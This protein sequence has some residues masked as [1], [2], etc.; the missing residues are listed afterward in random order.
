MLDEGGVWF[1]PSRGAARDTRRRRNR[2]PTN[3]AIDSGA[4]LFGN[5]TPQPPSPEPHGYLALAVFDTSAA[6]GDGDGSITSADA[7][8][9]ALRLWIDA[10]HDGI[11]QSHELSTLAAWEIEEV[12]LDYVASRRRDRHGNELRYASSVRFVRGTS[13]CADVFLLRE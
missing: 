11:S 6:G 13:Q 12:D 10:D 7:V 1:V 2:E 8:Y 4:E 3:G 9:P 5:F